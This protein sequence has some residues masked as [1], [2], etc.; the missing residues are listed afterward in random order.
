MIGD[1]IVRLK[2]HDDK[3]ANMSDYPSAWRRKLRVQTLV[4]IARIELKSGKEFDDFS[5]KLEEEMQIRWKL[6]QSTRKQYLDMVKRVL[7]N[8]LVLVC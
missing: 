2:D 1:L 6:V 4:E 3:H 8:Q 7:D 5:G